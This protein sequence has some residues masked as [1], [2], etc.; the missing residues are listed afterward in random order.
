MRSRVVL[1]L[2][3]WALLGLASSSIAEGQTIR[4]SPGNEAPLAYNPATQLYEERVNLD[5][6]FCAEEPCIELLHNIFEPLVSTSSAQVIEPQLATD[7]QR[8]DA[9]SF[10]FVLRRGVTFHNGE[11][12]DA[13]AVRFSLMRASEAYGATAWLPKIDRVDIVNPY[14]VDVVL[15]RPDSLFLYRLA[16]IGLIMPPQYFRQVGPTAFGAHP[17]G[18]GAFRFER[19]NQER[20]EIH[21]AANPS[22]WRRGYPKVERLVYAYM[23][24]EQAL[25]R[26]IDRELDLIRRLNPRKTTE[27]MRTGAG[28]VVKAWLPQVVL[29]PFNLLKSETPLKEPGVRQAINLSINREHLIRYGTI[30]NGRVMAGYTVP[31]DPHHVDLQPYQLDLSKARQLLAGAGYADG[32]TLAMLVDRQVPPQ[33]ENIIVISLQQIGI[34]IEV[35]RAGEAEFL[36]ELYLPKFGAAAPPSFDILLLSMPAGTIYHS[37]M[38]PMTLLY[39]KKPNESA[40]RDPVL[41]QLYEEAVQTYDPSDAGPLWQRLEQYVHANHLL[42]MGYQEKAVF[43]ANERLRFVPRTLMTF[44]DAYFQE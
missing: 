43:G 15:R 7:W 42:F 37:A 9:V 39:S 14:V 19:W 27:F 35:K 24:A 23:D 1:N 12:F 36:N 2:M 11:P 3:A 41:D 21:M 22:Y 25:A 29:G 33:I 44:W 18:T 16:N 34:T 30:G 26:L 31:E 5:P 4:F 10:R 8:L 32:F 6:L 17:V 38:V 28:R 20:R 13:E 40:I